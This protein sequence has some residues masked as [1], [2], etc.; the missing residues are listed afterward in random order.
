MDPVLNNYCY[1]RKER[2]QPNKQRRSP[3]SLSAI[4]EWG[5]WFSRELDDPTQIALSW[6]DSTSIIPPPPN[7]PNT[8]QSLPARVN[9]GRIINHIYSVNG[10][11]N[12]K[13]PQK[14]FK[15]KRDFFLACFFYLAYAAGFDSGIIRGLSQ[16]RKVP[17]MLQVLQNRLLTE[18]GVHVPNALLQCEQLLAQGSS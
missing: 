9:F 5:S 6:A 17:P 4:S 13:T 7:S 2:S 15:K 16:K 14:K 1:S 11:K 12:I 18:P 10:P 8:L 3:Q